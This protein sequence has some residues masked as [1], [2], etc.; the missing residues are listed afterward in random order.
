MQG[1]YYY[2]EILVMI[3]KMLIIFCIEYLASVAGE[4]QILTTMLVVVVSTV[5]V[6]Y[7]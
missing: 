4:V 5:S 7:S 3:R 1:D 6:V 2:W